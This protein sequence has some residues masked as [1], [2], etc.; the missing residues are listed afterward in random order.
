VIRVHF[1][2][3]ALILS[4]CSVPVTW[5]GGSGAYP[6]GAE[7]FMAGA[8]PPPGTYLLLYSNYYSADR[9]KDDHGDNYGAGPLADVDISVWANVLRVL[10]VTKHKILGADWAVQT[11][12]PFVDMDFDFGPG[13]RAMSDSRSGLGDI[14]VDPLVL[15]WHGQNFHWVAGLDIFLPTGKY[16][17][18]KEPINPGNNVWTFEPVFGIS[19]LNGP[20][21]LSVK[22][23]YDF[24]TENDDY[25]NP[26]S[27]QTV[28]LT[29]GQEFHC[30][31]AL[32]YSFAERWTAGLSGYFYQ[33]TTDDE[34]AGADVPNQKGRVLA[35]GPTVKFAHKNMSFTLKSLFETE[36]KN[37]PAGNSTWFRFVYAF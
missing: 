4:L 6:N 29:P 27:G 2:I 30:D 33:Q 31:Y 1:A 5:A 21:D 11:L 17:A 8:V 26:A 12:I 35:V 15:A 32:G 19:F 3:L 9:Y 16:N 18:D 20:L 36:V 13:F 24:S 23:M 14:I 37:R 7:D 34:V 25:L 10:H 22:L 28:D